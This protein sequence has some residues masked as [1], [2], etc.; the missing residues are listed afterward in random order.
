MGIKRAFVKFFG[1]FDF[2]FPHKHLV[3]NES[4]LIVRYISA[5]SISS[6]TQ[7]FLFWGLLQF[8]GSAYYL[9][10]SVIAFVVALLVSFTLQKFWTFKERSLHRLKKQFRLYGIVALVNVFM[11]AALMYFFVSLFLMKY[12]FAQIVTM[13]MVAVWSFLVHRIVTFNH[14]NLHKVTEKK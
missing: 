4:R 12:L 3:K 14:E 9:L 8:F 10:S 1:K 11:N 6:G 2:P 7:I 5:G 13:G